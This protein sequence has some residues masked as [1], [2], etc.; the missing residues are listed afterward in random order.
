MN[1][2]SFELLF[3]ED[4]HLSKQLVTGKNFCAYL[5]YDI[6]LPVSLLVCFSVTEHV[7]EGRPARRGLLPA[8][9][10][11]VCDLAA[12]AQQCSANRITIQKLPTQ[13]S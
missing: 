12:A 9:G 4:I 2:N 11:V 10:L 3:L 6:S 1:A 8:K 5:T 13:D 7:L